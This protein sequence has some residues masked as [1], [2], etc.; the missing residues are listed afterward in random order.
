MGYYRI[1]QCPGRIF[2]VSHA[3]KMQK[4]QAQMGGQPL[5][6]CNDPK[7]SKNRSPSRSTGDLAKT[8]RGVSS[9]SI[10]HLQDRQDAPFLISIETNISGGDYLCSPEIRDAL[11]GRTESFAS[12]GER[13]Q[14]CNSPCVRRQ[15]HPVN[16]IRF[17]VIEATPATSAKAGEATCFSSAQFWPAGVAARTDRSNG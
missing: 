17:L 10:K 2:G 15:L 11:I 5:H 12:D 6:G 16:G 9:M 3:I 8:V 13:L 14:R 4:K 1:S 7:R